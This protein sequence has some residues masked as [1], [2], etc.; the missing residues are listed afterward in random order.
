MMRG[1]MALRLF[2]VELLCDGRDEN[3]QRDSSL[4]GGAS[5][6]TVREKRQAATLFRM[7]RGFAA[8]RLFV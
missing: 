1:F 3:Q 4:R 5:R 8:L 7:T 2:A 6:G